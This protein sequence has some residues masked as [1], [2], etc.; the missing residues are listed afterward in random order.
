MP[1][2]KGQSGNPAGRPRGSRNRKTIMLQNMLDEEGEAIL[3]RAMDMAKDG[4]A[5]AL[6]LCMDRLLPTRRHEPLQC[7]LPPISRAADAVT[8]MGDIAAAVGTGEVAPAEAV[9][10]AKVVTGFV[11]ALLTHGL[12]E[13]LTSVEAAAERRERLAAV[14]PTPDA[15]SDHASDEGKFVPYWRTRNDQNNQTT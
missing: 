1:F 11:Q 5:F 8:A 10:L 9:A 2:E 14:P 6:R 4:N 15:P 12:D 13:R 7:E 3:Q